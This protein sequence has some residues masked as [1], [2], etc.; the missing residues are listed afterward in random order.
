MAI[1]Y[2]RIAF[3]AVAE[4]PTDDAPGVQVWDHRQLQPALTGPDVADIARLSPDKRC[5]HRCECTSDWAFCR[6]VTLQQVRCDAEPVIA[7]ALA[8]GYRQKIFVTKVQFG[9]I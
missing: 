8:S 3:H 7:G 1:F 9:R 2:A 6:E 5:V 4:G